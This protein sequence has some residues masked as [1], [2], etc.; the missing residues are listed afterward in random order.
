MK[1]AIVFLKQVPLST[2]VA[3]DPV[4]ERHAVVNFPVC[5]DNI[6]RIDVEETKIT[7]A[8]RAMGMRVS[9]GHDATNIQGADLVVYSAAIHDDNPELSAARSHGIPA[10]ERSVVVQ[11]RLDA[12]TDFFEHSV[13]E[14]TYVSRLA[15]AI[16]AQHVD[17]LVRLV[18]QT[19]RERY[20]DLLRRVPDVFSRV[21][22]RDVAAYVGIDPATLS[23]MR[24]AL[25]R[26]PRPKP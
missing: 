19:P 17:R 22:L 6:Y 8:E 23:R 14:R 18:G 15:E 3:I 13:G 16:A 20:F 25:L 7:E 5:K 24:T 26:E 2:K 10:V 12:H 9:L 11:I 21:S 1:R 4:T